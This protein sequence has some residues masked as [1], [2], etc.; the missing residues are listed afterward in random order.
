MDQGKGETGGVYLASQ[1]E[2]TPTTLLLMVDRVKGGEGVHPPP[3][4]SPRI[5]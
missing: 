5:G 1:L 4:P 3:P 2:P